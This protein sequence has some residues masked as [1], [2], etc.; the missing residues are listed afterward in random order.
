[1]TVNEAET[2]ISSE[3]KNNEI[4]IKMI[5]HYIS[6]LDEVS[7]IT[8]IVFLTRKG[9]RDTVKMFLTEFYPVENEHPLQHFDT[10]PLV[11]SR[12]KIQTV[13]QKSICQGPTK[14]NFN[15]LVYGLLMSEELEFDNGEED[16]ARRELMFATF[17]YA[18]QMNENI[19]ALY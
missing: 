18:K 8:T 5:E 11:I 14:I 19:L 17:P 6:V 13:L 7:D 9:T 4:L 1:M 12:K 10:N 3:D 15:T 2:K 16:R